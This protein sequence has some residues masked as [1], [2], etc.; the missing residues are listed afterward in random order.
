VL[1]CKKIINGPNCWWKCLCDFSR[2][3]ASSQKLQVQVLQKGTYLVR[4][5]L[6]RGKSLNWNIKISTFYKNLIMSKLIF[7]LGITLSSTIK[8]STL[9]FGVG[10]DQKEI[11]KKKWILMLHVVL[12]NCGDF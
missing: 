5:R 1:N 11:S 2:I 3:S 7:K 10:Q 8:K 4:R 12:R 6:N 9:G